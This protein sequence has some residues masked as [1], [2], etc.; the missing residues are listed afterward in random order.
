MGTEAVRRRAHRRASRWGT[1][2]LAGALLGAATLVTAPAASAAVTGDVVFAG[3]GW[4]HGRG[5]GQW[6]AYG[7]AVNHGWD[8]RRILS[9]YYGGTNQSSEPNAP[10]TVHLTGRDGQDL[11]VTSA[12]DFTVGG[13]VVTGGSAARVQAQADGSFVLSTSYGCAS[14]TVWTTRIPSSQVVPSVREGAGLDAML[15]LC[16]PTGTTQ[17]RGDLS[18]VWSGGTQ[19]TVNT[20]LMEEYLRG[21]V[22]RESVPSWGDAG[23]GKGLEALKAQA[24]AARSYAWAERRTTYARTCDT[25]ACQVYRGAGVNMKSTEDRRTDAA[26]A[27]TAGVVLR[28]GGGAIVR[29]E[30]SAST[31]GW[32]AGGTFP[33]VPDEGDTASPHHDWI[34]PVAAHTIADAFGVG[35]LNEITVTGRNGLGADGGRVT[36][37]RIAGTAK[38]V[39]VTGAQVRSKL[40]LKSDWFS[41]AVSATAPPPP[42]PPV[43]PVVYLASGN[44]PG[45]TAQAVP[46]GQT[47]DVPLLCDWDGDGDDTLGV[48]R[49][50]VFHVTNAAGSGRAEASFGYGSPGDQPVCGDWDGNGTETVGVYRSG[51]VHLRNSNTPGRADGSFWFGDRGDVLVAGNWDGDPFDTVGVWRRGVFH[52]TNSN[53]RPVADAVVPYGAPDDLPVTG[54]WDGN[55]SDTVAVYRGDRFFVRNSNTIGPADA[56]VPFGAPG[57]RPLRGRPAATG[58]DVMG[59]SRAY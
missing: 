5:L 28:S 19:R 43:Q 23:G 40:G 55:G 1:G 33:P 35:A 48:F 30:F 29:T 31:G 21:V 3:H 24:V 32:T 50:G 46:F 27:A 42:P 7:Y 58:P 54:D 14:P 39:T 53:L 18:V 37:V 45:A 15:S 17:Y 12:R 41:V 44:A 20:V 25:T 34:L 22:P 6:G 13:V 36:E 26:V 52:L 38:S 49:G 11:H 59:V 10:L 16:E 8:Y 9:H 57:D 56:V 51:M 4:G 2:V 47:G